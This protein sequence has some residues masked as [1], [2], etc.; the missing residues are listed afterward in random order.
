MP[1][2]HSPQERLTR[3]FFGE[4]IRDVKKVSFLSKRLKS[5]DSRTLDTKLLFHI[6]AMDGQAQ[7]E[8]LFSFRLSVYIDQPFV[9]SCCH[10]IAT[11]SQVYNGGYIQNK[12]EY[13]N[14]YKF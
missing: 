13:F 12:N 4:V 7:I 14:C 10:N 8:I 6:K 11:R 3:F 5:L 9:L 2:G 1:F